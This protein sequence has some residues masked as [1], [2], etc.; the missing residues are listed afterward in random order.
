MARGS[1]LSK[2][3]FCKLGTRREL[4]TGTT[5][6]AA[7]AAAAAASS[8]ALSNS[9][10]PSTLSIRTAPAAD[11]SSYFSSTFTS[12]GQARGFRIR[13]VSLDV[14]AFHHRGKKTLGRWKNREEQKK[15]SLDP[16]FLPL[17]LF[18]LFNKELAAERKAALRADLAVGHFDDLK[19][20]KTAS[21]PFAARAVPE[22]AA[23]L[24]PS[25]DLAVVA[26]ETGGGGESSSGSGSGATT[27]GEVLSRALLPDGGGRG[28]SLGTRRGPL[29]LFLGSRAS[30]EPALDS[31]ARAAGGG[32][33]APSPD[34]RSPPPSPP[35]PP[36]LPIVDLTLF[37][38]VSPILLALPGGKGALLR[39]AAEGARRRGARVAAAHFGSGAGGARALREALGATNALAGYACVLDCEVEEGGGGALT[40]RA[41]VRWIGAGE[42][43]AAE[44]PGLREVVASLLPAGGAAPS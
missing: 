38:R 2:Q 40:A 26:R 15:L 7:T 13:D 22:G 1:A 37:D 39:G 23:L 44:G 11:Y 36:L 16:F 17:D 43:E 19:G 5:A 42:A 24:L 14:A 32:P 41:R 27:L 3:L 4:S 31:W 10:P 8:L 28:G 20:A 12:R 18:Q 35:S 9:M 29:L 34:A 33:P 21:K 6:A 25:L 30:A